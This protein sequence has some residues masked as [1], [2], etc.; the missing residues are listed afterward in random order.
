MRSHWVVLILVG[1]MLAACSS[2]KGTEPPESEGFGS[3]SVQV[4]TTAASETAQVDADGYSV[5]LGG[6]AVVP[7]GPNGT[8]EF[9]DVPAVVM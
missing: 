5:R 6:E 3:L 2:D 8:V 7:V 9:R 4:S 1:C